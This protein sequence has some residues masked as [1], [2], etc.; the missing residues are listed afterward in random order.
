[1]QTNAL[2]SLLRDPG[3][4]THL[5]G[6]QWHAVIESGR[7]TQLLGQL[8]ALLAREGLLQGVP[9]PVRKHLDLAALTALRRLQSALW[10][11]RVIRQA[12]DP[13]IPLT[14]LK[15]GAYAACADRSGHGRLFSDVD[16]L[17]SRQHLAATEVA[18]FGAG[19][20]P[21][22][23]SAYD[24]AYY[25]NWMHEVPPMEHVRRHTVVDLH[26]AINP[27]ISRLY[28][29]PNLLL[30]SKVEVQPG[31]FV[32]CA[33]DRVV[34]CCIHLLQEG[35]PKKLLRDLFDL[36]LLVIQHFGSEDQRTSLF[37]RAAQLG[38]EPQVQFAIGAARTLFADPP[39]VRTAWFQG[40]IV[41]SALEANGKPK[42]WRAAISDTLL[43]AYSHWVKMP[44]HI[45]VP[46]LARKSWLRLW[47]ES[48]GKA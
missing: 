40:C 29:D 3:P 11:I 39:T 22:P 15:G 42:S 47:P 45:L 34:H 7:K 31:V 1:M 24:A 26:H 25:R 33:T 20:K 17:V 2:I 27:P 14:L 44:M 46:H 19:W 6:E 43:L 18:L 30:E 38:V 16:L 37:A 36:H 35:E 12:V 5:R 41:R 10:E 23:V 13:G 21:S 4:A 9:S 8:A 28:V 32:L 48:G